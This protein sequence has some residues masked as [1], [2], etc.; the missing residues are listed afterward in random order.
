[1]NALLPIFS[2][3]KNIRSLYQSI[4]NKSLFKRPVEPI[5]NDLA[6]QALTEREQRR[7]VDPSVLDDPLV[8]QRAELFVL[9]LDSVIRF[10][11]SAPLEPNNPDA[12]RYGRYIW[13]PY[14][15]S[16]AYMRGL[17]MKLNKYEYHGVS[18][19][20]NLNNQLIEAIE[21]LDTD[22]IYYIE[23]K[24]LVATLGIDNRHLLS[25]RFLLNRDLGNR[26][27]LW[28]SSYNKVYSAIIRSSIII[29]HNP[30][31]DKGARHDG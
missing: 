2:D 14:S 23:Q 19:N 20:E 18:I 1:M 28:F 3:F 13:T 9:I 21:L 12:T 31:K 27:V 15:P 17:A 7:S 8:K 26:P 4:K 6:I 16:N 24:N 5:K 22:V 11:P 25:V 29:P 30:N 10:L